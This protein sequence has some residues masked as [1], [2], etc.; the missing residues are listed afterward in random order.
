MLTWEHGED[1]PLFDEDDKPILRGDGAQATWSDLIACFGEITRRK[2]GNRIE[3]FDG[4]D[5]ES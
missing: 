4:L 3:I 2:Y 1:Y 5:D